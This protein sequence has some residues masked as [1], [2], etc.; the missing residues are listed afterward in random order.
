MEKVFYFGSTATDSANFT[1]RKADTERLITN[2]KNGINTI[3]ISPRRW[4]K[5]SLVKHACEQID[6]KKDNLIIVFMDIFSCRSEQDFLR[7]YSNA[8]IRQTS[9]NI[10]EWMSIAK[11]FLSR[12]NPV[13]SF[14]SDPMNDFSMSFSFTEGKEDDFD[15]LD[16]PEKIAKKKNLNIVVC[17]DEFQQILDFENN[18]NFQKKLRTVWQ[19]HNNVSYCLFGSKKHLMTLLFGSKSLPFYKFGDV[20]YLQKISQDDWVKY[21]RGQF[22]K[23]N[24]SISNEFAE[25]ICQ[26]VDNH[27]SYVQQLSYILFNKCENEVTEADLQYAIEDLFGQNAPLF[28]RDTENLSMYQ[29]N[30]VKA[31]CNDVTE[32]FTSKDIL[33]K[34]NLGSVSNVSRIKKSLEQ[35]ELIDITNGKVTLL[36]LVYKMWFL[37]YVIGR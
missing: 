30:F 2:F 7:Q 29:M 20:I 26:I 25:R 37:K 28:I 23:F 17:I 33:I 27:S 16:L 8:V 34:Y 9:S 24:K 10:E 31:L 36:D 14:G 5:T 18:I 22:S 6:A 32:N 3:L 12:I 4:G 35:K 13:F 15:I 11:N 1:D 19:H 21:I